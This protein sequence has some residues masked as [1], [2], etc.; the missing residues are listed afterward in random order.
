[1]AAFSV[2][3]M[4]RCERITSEE[5][6]DFIGRYANTLEVAKSQFDGLCPQFVNDRY[7]I[8]HEKIEDIDTISMENYVYSSIPK[9]YGLMDTTAVAATGSIQLQQMTGFQLTGRNVM[10]GFIDTGIDYTNNI[11]RFSTGQTRIYSIWDQ[12]D[13]SGNLPDGFD[14]GSE[15][16]A[17]EINQALNRDNPYEVVPHRD[18]NGHG[19]FMAS[20]SCGSENV[21]ND[22]VG[23]AP[24]SQL[25]VVKLK[26]AKQYLKDYFY[27]E[28][29]EVYQENDIMLA[30]AYLRSVQLRENK[31]MVIVLG[32]GSGNGSRIGGSPLAQVLDD[33]GNIIGNCVLV[34]AGNE[35]NERLHYQGRIDDGEVDEVE[36]RVGENVEGMVLELW[37]LSPDIFSVSFVSPLGESTPEIAARKDA[38]ETIEFLLDGTV[39]EINYSLVE[40]GSGEEVILMRFTRPSA[41][42]WVIR[43]YG[44]NIL[45]GQFN[46]WGNLRQFTSE[47]TY[48]LNPQPDG[49]ITVPSGSNNIITVGGYDSYNNGIYPNTGRG[50]VDGVDQKPDVVAPSVDVF[51]AGLN[52]NFVRR[53]GTSVGVSLAAGCCAQ[54]LE[55][56]VVE[57]NEPYMKTNY[58]RNYLI[59]GA[60]RDRDI[61]YPSA[62]WG[63]GKI[64]LVE[65]FN[66]L[67]GL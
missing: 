9:L 42:I 3:V 59:R 16:L 43:V 39:L 67:V 60:D 2:T 64:N 45:Y 19:T 25:V 35:G 34:C 14:Y 28:G 15:Y 49:T 17:N 30:V 51:G 20:V 36:L 7:V 53:T 50:L 27:I 38:S 29:D 4:A 65:T 41:G 26:K 48:F 33:I 47:D 11:F 56:G 63:Y 18:D 13:E 22:F 46:I 61:N 37:G 52:N 24:D 54:L 31:P 6:A 44:N 40:S 12:T 8:L 1:M 32:M 62:Q 5:Y 10:I 58:I 23:A 66:R 57:E 55:W 21:A